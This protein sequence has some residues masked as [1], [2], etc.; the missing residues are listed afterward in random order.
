MK[1]AIEAPREGKPFGVVASWGAIMSKTTSI[2]LALVLCSALTAATP[3]TPVTL[4]VCA[5]GYPGTTVEAQPSMDALGDAVSKSVGWPAGTVK[6][7]YQETEEGGLAKYRGTAPMLALVPLPFYLAHGGELK[8]TAR[9]QAVPKDGK[10]TDVWTLVAKKGRVVSAASLSGW[11]IV[12]LAGYAPDFIRN[13]A[14]AKWGKLPP[15]VTFVATGQA[16][17]ALRKASSG[18]NVAVLLDGAQ[19]ASLAS[20]PFAQDLET[21]ATSAPLPAIVLCTV[22]PSLGP[23]DAKRLTTGLLKLN[24]NPAGAAALDGVRLARFVAPDDKAL[25]AAR[26]AYAPNPLAATK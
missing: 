14:L 9:L 3:P 15:D 18:D 1:R 19:T 8:L 13:V 25:A 11:K 26:K 23:V 22:G 21:V 24:E 5:P 12:S 2:P 7:E 20:L 10:D 16:L 6:A 17:S 4:V